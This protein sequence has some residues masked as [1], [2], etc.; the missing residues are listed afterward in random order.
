M[1][2][3]KIGLILVTIEGRLVIVNFDILLLNNNEVVLG[4]P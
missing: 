1:I 3:I 4:M 2:Y